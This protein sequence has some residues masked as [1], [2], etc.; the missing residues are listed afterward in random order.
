MLCFISIPSSFTKFTGKLHWHTLLK[1]RAIETGCYIFAPAQFGSHPGK[2]KTFGHSLI[3]D[4][5]GKIIKEAKNTQTVIIS[6][7][8]TKTVE[9]YTKSIPSIN[10]ENFL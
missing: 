7:I 10:L 6:E 9:V 8:N 3:V 5:W 1:A 4:P 2:K